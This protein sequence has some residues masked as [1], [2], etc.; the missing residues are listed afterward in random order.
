[1]IRKLT[2]LLVLSLV[3]AGAVM[4]CADSTKKEDETPAP[5]GSALPSG[6]VIIVGE[7]T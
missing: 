3:I 2:L 4:G 6:T 1:M 5:G 7:K